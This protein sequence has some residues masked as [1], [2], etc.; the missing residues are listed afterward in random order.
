MADIK[1]LTY[2]KNI[3]K[4]SFADGSLDTAFKQMLAFIVRHCPELTNEGVL[5]KQNYTSLRE[6]DRKGKISFTDMKIWQNKVTDSALSLLDYATDLIVEGHNPTNSRLEGGYHETENNE[7]QANEKKTLS[8]KIFINANLVSSEKFI[9]ESLVGAIAQTKHKV[10]VDSN[11]QSGNDWALAT[12]YA[13]EEADFF[14][15]LLSQDNI[16]SE[17]LIEKIKI[18]KELNSRNGRPEILPIRMGIPFSEALPYELAFNI[19]SVSQKEWKDEKDTDRLIIEFIDYINGT[20]LEWSG[21]IEEKVASVNSEYTPPP[22]SYFDPGNLR[23]P[24]GAVDLESSY[25]IER[26]SDKVMNES[27]AL[28]RSLVTLK[29][30]RQTGKSSLVIRSYAMYK[31]KLEHSQAAF[32]DFQIFEKTAFDSIKSIWKYV[33][34]QIADQLQLY[35]WESTW[36][37][38]KPFNFNL[39]YFLDRHV[40]E[41]K[42]SSLL[43]CLDEVDYLFNFPVYREFFSSIRAFYN[44]GAF[45]Q[46]WKKV[47]WILST[48]T[49]PSF[50]IDDVMQSPFNVGVNIELQPFTI[51]QTKEFASRLGILLTVDQI[52][53]ICDFTGG[54]PFLVHLLLYSLA[55]GALSIDKLNHTE[56]AIEN[57]FRDHLFRYLIHFQ[58]NEEMAN[59]MK[60]IISGNVYKNAK[61]IDRLEGAGL[62]KRRNGTVVPL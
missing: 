41:H 28:K 34:E 25:Y 53:K 18:V 60:T 44:K 26:S 17:S 35:E 14:L 40:L 2:E 59:A 50:F 16:H 24:G 23:I 49:E 37:D 11:T 31:E 43:I 3:I 12:R 42:D 36:N 45:D 38:D 1:K 32:I 55:K 62:V 21:A 10:F 46:S 9:V 13:L 48:S 58:D 57:I 15:L 6:E 20:V 8:S 56:T 30:A 19:Q 52:N 39:T 4:D 7:S 51:D 47:S 33:V 5:I 54:K 27:I 61:L 22:F 29:G